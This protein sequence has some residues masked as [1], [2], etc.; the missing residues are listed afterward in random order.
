MT[1][2]NSL[3][4]KAEAGQARKSSNKDDK[5]GEYMKNKTATIEWLVEH[6]DEYGSVTEALVACPTT[7]RKTIKSIMAQSDDASIIEQC[8]LHPHLDDK[9][10]KKFVEEAAPEVREQFGEQ[11]TIRYA[12]AA[13][14]E[15]E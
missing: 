7:A 4:Q 6:G 10:V 9:A 13:K 8:L 5:S 15:L 14:L 3:V 12:N 1:S 11:V 2:L